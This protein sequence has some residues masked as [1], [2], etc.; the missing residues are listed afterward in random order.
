MKA[1][2]KTQRP[3]QHGGKTRA[4]AANPAISQHA[5]DNGDL[6]PP[7]PSST[8]RSF[9]T[10]AARLASMTET[11]SS[12]GTPVTVTFDHP[13]INYIPEG[14]QIE[15]GYTVTPSGQSATVALRTESGTG[16][17]AF[18]DD[19]T[20]MVISETGTLT[21]KAI[22]VSSEVNNIVL[23]VES[24][25]QRWFSIIRAQIQAKRGTKILD[26]KW[27]PNEGSIDNL[28]LRA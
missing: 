20:S 18:G 13:E 7:I 17:A 19:S 8:A 22:T 5:D 3:T 12:S 2:M 16:E 14:G 6:G 10:L 15:L 25:D 24:V 26:D 9:S 27:A 11:S 23:G 1:G 4:S 21:I 28:R